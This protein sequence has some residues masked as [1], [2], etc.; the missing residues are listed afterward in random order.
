MRKYLVLIPILM[1]LAISQNSKRRC[2]FT[3]PID[4]TLE[5]LP[6]TVAKEIWSKFKEECD[7]L[8]LT[9]QDLKDGSPVSLI[10]L[11]DDGEMEYAI[12]AAAK[13]SSGMQIL[14]GAS[15]NGLNFIYQ[16]RGEEY[17]L[18]LEF[19][20]STGW[21]SENKT[22]GYWDIYGSEHYSTNSSINTLYEWRG[23]KYITIQRI[24]FGFDASEIKRIESVK[25][26]YLSVDSLIHLIEE[27]LKYAKECD[28]MMIMPPS[29]INW[30]TIGVAAFLLGVKGDSTAIPILKQVV[31][32]PTYIIFPHTHQ[33]AARDEAAKSFVQLVLPSSY[34]HLTTLEKAETLFYFIN[35]HDFGE[36]PH[37]RG[38]RLLLDDLSIEADSSYIELLCYYLREGNENARYLTSNL[39]AK[40]PSERA[41][42]CL[43]NALADSNIS[44][45]CNVIRLF[46]LFPGNQNEIYKNLEDIFNNKTNPQKI[47]ERVLR[48]ISGL[49]IE[50]QHIIK[51]LEDVAN[52]KTEDSAIR[53]IANDLKNYLL[54]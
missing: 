9:L 8:D 7:I 12:E 50:E 29:Y 6:D 32:T 34:I 18:I 46:G 22:K 28:S 13:D 49:E 31:N 41:F 42:E 27:T 11:N 15:G 10:D 4:M 35:Q 30:L 16:K 38:V 53:R 14:R 43:K 19:T 52:N 37:Y 47:R 17:F 2:L 21:F 54:Q 5:S 20:G 3:H 36:Q 26:Q 33:S 39:L 1:T 51:F 48:S 45:R 44:V 40:N 24:Y 23:K 25:L